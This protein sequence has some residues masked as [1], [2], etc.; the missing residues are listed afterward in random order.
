MMA[1]NSLHRV[2]I[3]DCTCKSNLDSVSV[4]HY[5]APTGSTCEILYDTVACEFTLQGTWSTSQW[6][7]FDFTNLTKLSEKHGSH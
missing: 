1:S 6:K 5:P 2:F 7:N 3:T 4:Q